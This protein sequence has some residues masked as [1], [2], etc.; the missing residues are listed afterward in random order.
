MTSSG[1]PANGR[2]HFGTGNTDAKFARR[3]EE[4]EVWAFLELVRR[5]LFERL[6][7]AQE[8]VIE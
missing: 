8:A 7:D 6:R 3:S 4:K 1:N 5:E 2:A